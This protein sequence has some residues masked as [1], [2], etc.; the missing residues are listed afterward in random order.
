M[1]AAAA[2]EPAANAPDPETIFGNVRKAWGAGAYP[3]FAEYAIVVEYHKDGRHLKHTWDTTE[4]LRHNA[5]YSRMFSR[6]QRNYMGDPPRGTNIALPFFGTLNKIQ[7]A[8]PIGHVSFAVDRDDGMA[9]VE[10]R[11]VTPS[12]QYDF[13]R[14]SSTLQVIGRTGTTARD[15][16]VSLIETLHDAEGPEYHL[17]LRPLHDPMRYRLRELYVDGTTWR[18]EE[19]IV[20]GIANRAPLTKVPWRVEYRQVDGATYIASE[21]ALKD[22]DYGKAGTLRWVTVSFE[23]LKRGAKPTRFGSEFGLG[24]SSDDPLREP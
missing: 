22:L 9:P 8:D 15:Y 17:A 12:S 7:P 2:P 20:D 13:N 1:G 19:A 16:D 4:D 5:V 18:P 24:N 11:F 10:R 21:T 23:E 14:R 6:E 3:R